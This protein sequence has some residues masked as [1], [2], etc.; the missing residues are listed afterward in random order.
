MILDSA[1]GGLFWDYQRG[2]PL[3]CPLSP[4]LGG[5]FLRELDQRLERLGLLYIRYMD[6]ILVLAPTRWKLRRAVRELNQVLA[7]L[8]VEKQPAKTFIGRIEKGFDFLGYHLRPDQISVS[9]KTQQKFA[10]RIHR[11]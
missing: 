2:I 8:G 9:Q 6:D 5:F 4:V 1:Q 7:S 3:G 11:L 10:E